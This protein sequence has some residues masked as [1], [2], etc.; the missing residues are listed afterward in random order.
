MKATLGCTGVMVVNRACPFANDDSH[1]GSWCPHF[2]DDSVR[3]LG[4][5]GLVAIADGGKVLY[6]LI[7]ICHN[8]R[9]TVDVDSA[10]IAKFLNVEAAYGN[11]VAIATGD[12]VLCPACGGR[13]AS[14]GGRGESAECGLCKGVGCIAVAD[15]KPNTT[16]GEA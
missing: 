11:T 3:V 1:C 7:G 5:R 4:G 14:K 10:E 2:D 9:I 16:G 12:K 15:L 8:K 6:A 13:G